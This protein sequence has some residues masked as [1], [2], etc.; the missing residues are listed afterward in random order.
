MSTQSENSTRKRNTAKRGIG[1]QEIKTISTVTRPDPALYL[2]PATVSASA[3]AA[4]TFW[5]LVD[6]LSVLGKKEHSAAAGDTKKYKSAAVREVVAL[7]NTRLLRGGLKKASSVESKIPDVF[8]IYQDVDYLK[9]CS[10]IH[11][12]D[13]RGC[14]ITTPEEDLVWK[15]IIANRPGCA[16]FRNKG[17]PLYEYVAALCPDKA[18]GTHAF[19]PSNGSQGTLVFDHHGPSPPPGSPSPGATVFADIGDTEAIDSVR[20]D[21]YFDTL[22]LSQEIVSRARSPSSGRSASV[23]VSPVK[24]LVTLKRAVEESPEK[25]PRKRGRFTD[26]TME[27]LAGGADVLASAIAQSAEKLAGALTAGIEASP[28]R[29]AKAADLALER[30]SAWLSFPDRFRLTAVLE[31]TVK[32]DSYLKYAVQGSPSRRGW[33]AMTLNLPLPDD[34]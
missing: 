27:K 29:R 17:W 20:G 14:N 6:M 22:D 3:K 23:D 24:K 5:C 1:Y 30:D 33:V 28:V 32:A 7:L 15:T 34:I 4:W 16:P 18:K 9:S 11:Y 19:R 8:A 12:D 10:G 2:D 13:I 21:D 31:E 25:K 26:E